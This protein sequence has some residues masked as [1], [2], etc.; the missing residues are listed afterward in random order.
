MAF[1]F[2]KR[3]T[4]KRSTDEKRPREESGAW[5]S[6][7]YGHAARRWHDDT[8]GWTD[9]VEGVGLEPDKTGIARTD[10]AAALVFKSTGSQDDGTATGTA[11]DAAEG[12]HVVNA[13]G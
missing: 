9:R 2:R 3:S 10:E 8:R 5:Y 4:G 7:L 11:G 1:T 6:D 12:K 13:G